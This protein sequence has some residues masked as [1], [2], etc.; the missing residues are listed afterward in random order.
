MALL[1]LMVQEDKSTR[2]LIYCCNT[3][4]HITTDVG[5]ISETRSEMLTE[6]AHKIS[7]WRV[8]SKY[9]SAWPEGKE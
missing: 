7:L 2:Y 5:N 9:L 4:V 8:S 1:W 6:Q 3:L